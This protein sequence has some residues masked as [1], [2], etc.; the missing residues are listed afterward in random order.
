MLYDT[1]GGFQLFR[2]PV[3]GHIMRHRH[4]V[5]L[6]VH[7]A[8]LE[9][10]VPDK[11]LHSLD[12]YRVDAVREVVEQ[13][14]LKHGHG[15]LCVP[16]TAFCELQSLAVQLLDED[17]FAF[18]LLERGGDACPDSRVRQFY[19][20]AV[21]VVDIVLDTCNPHQYA[22]SLETLVR[23]PDIPS[24]NNPASDIDPILF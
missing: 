13:G 12:G 9:A 23:E 15:F 19:D 3:V 5:G 20:R 6:A 4:G 17:F 14:I 18:E 21:R 10:F 2:R 22:L 24:E 1:G 16:E 8:E 7:E 11:H